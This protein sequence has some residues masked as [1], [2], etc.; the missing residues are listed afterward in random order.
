M[1]KN[2]TKGRKK[3]KQEEAMTYR[4]NLYEKLQAEDIEVLEAMEKSI[5][6]NS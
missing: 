3:T 5:K 1:R 4:Q 6:P 2:K